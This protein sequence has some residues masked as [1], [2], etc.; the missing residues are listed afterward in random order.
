MGICE[1]ILLYYVDACKRYHESR[2]RMKRDQQPERHQQVEIN[3]AN[4]RRKGYR[5]RVSLKNDCIRK[6]II[7]SYIRIVIQ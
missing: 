2:R 6:F 5:T 3:K 4:A 1:S 7:A